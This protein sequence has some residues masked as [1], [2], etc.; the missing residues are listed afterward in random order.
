[1]PI[2]PQP[3]PQEFEVLQRPEWIE[4]QEYV[5]KNFWP[6]IRYIDPEERERFSKLS[7]QRQTRELLLENLKAV[8]EIAVTPIV[9]GGSQ[10]VKHGFKRVS[11]PV[12]EKLF[13]KTF[14][15]ISENADEIRTSQQIVKE[16]EGDIMDSMQV[17]QMDRRPIVQDAIG[18]IEGEKYA[19]SV[20]IQRQAIRKEAKR[21]ELELFEREG[22]K[23]KI[24]NDQAIES[25]NRIYER[26]RS[27][28]DFLA[29][30]LA[31]IKAGKTPGFEEELAH[32]VLNAT[33]LE[34]LTLATRLTAQGKMSKEA[35]KSI[36]DRTKDQFLNVTNPLASDAGRRLQSYNIEVGKHRA[37]KAIGKLKKGMNER[38]RKLLS[39][40]DFEDPHSMA[41]FEKELPNPRL[42]DYFYEF[43]YNSI[44]SGI[45]TH[46]VN[47]VSNTAWR[48]FQIPHKALVIGLDNVG[49]VLKGQSRKRYFGELLPHMAGL[50]RGR[51]KALRSAWQVARHGKITEM[52]SKWAKEIGPSLG[53]WDRSPNKVVRGVGKFITPPTKALRAMDVYANSIAFD[54]QLASI[55]KRTALQQKVPR[56]A[57]KAFIKKFVENPPQGAYDEA[58]DYAKY[59]T[60]MSDPGWV[61]SAIINARDRVPLGLGRLVVPFVNTIGNLTKRGVEMTPG[62]GLTVARGKRA[63]EVIAKQI[64]GSIIALTVMGKVMNGEMTGEAP[65]N[66]SERKAFY[67]Q[68]KKAWS[69]KVGDQWV[70]Y[71]R[72]EPFNSILASTYIAYSRIQEAMEEGGEVAAT[73]IFTNVANDWKNNLLDSSYLQGVTKLL[74]RYGARD[75]AI[76]RTASSLVPYSGFWRS[77]NRAY[78]AHTEGAA[79]VREPETWLEHMGQVIPSRILAGPK[80]LDVFGEPK[81]LEGGWFR[82][83]LPYRWS[84]ATK[85]A[86]ELGLE[87]LEVYPGLPS[88]QFKYK[89][90]KYEFDDDTYREFLS[91]YGPKAKAWLDKVFAMKHWQNKMETETGKEQLREI[92]EGNLSGLRSR[93]RGK[94][95]R[96]QIL[97]E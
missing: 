66:E 64:E 18:D 86:T 4:S 72:I 57:H 32:R 93:I 10:I 59:T 97:K 75:T 23:T 17:G 67:R 48:T 35:F 28:P 62:I 79:Y 31:D 45:P 19:G 96:K 27:D 15:N 3:Y 56:K 13:P 91:D 65:Q 53:A 11:N 14:K 85:D 77:I 95:I 26:F 42:R 51:N 40:V 9:Q 70:Q 87:K 52:E 6:Y 92:I 39:E 47:A 12:W 20:N 68:G 43:W 2:S 94:Y 76:P 29:K 90:K 37:L 73:K 58:F 60:F 74:N 78:E 80:S 82:Q 71:R 22:F 49:T 69:M 16:A 8:G 36:E 25:A 44:L 54:A 61:S 33:A 21:I 88:Q 5:R 34:E 24:S 38:Q 84:T 55:A 7:Q 30:S 41:A 50:V 89:R 81:K 1:M 83:W 63:S 46:F